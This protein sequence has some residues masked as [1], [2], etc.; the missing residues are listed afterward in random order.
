M[1]DGVFGVFYDAILVKEN[2][3]CT[4]MLEMNT[5]STFNRMSITS[6]SSMLDLDKVITKL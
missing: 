2:S 5:I 6:L 3:P 1:V 4:M